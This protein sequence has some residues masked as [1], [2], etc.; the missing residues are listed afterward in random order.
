ML[1]RFGGRIQSVFVLYFVSSVPYDACFTCCVCLPQE[2]LRFYNQ[3]TMQL[4]ML[5]FSRQRLVSDD[6]VSAHVYTLFV[7]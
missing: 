6:E 4:Q 1:V 7:C 5:E 2:A 3:T